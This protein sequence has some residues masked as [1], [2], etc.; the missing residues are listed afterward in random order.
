MTG[1]SII[2]MEDSAVKVLCRF[3][4]NVFVLLALTAAASAADLS[5]LKAQIER[6][7]P[8][9]RGE[10]GV[11]IK[12]LESG[13]EVLV[14]ADSR[15]PMASAFKLPILVELYYQKA[16]GKLSLE[17]HVDIEPAD[18]HIG[19]GAMIA[20]F[21]PPGVQINIRNLI[22]MMMR[23]SDNSAADILLKRVGPANVT[24]RMKA[25]GLDSIR[26]DRTTQEMIL[27]QSG[28][29]YS[30]YGALPVREVRKMLD[31]VDVPTAARANDQFNRTDKDVAKPGDMNA[32]LEKLYRGQIVDRSTSDEIIDILKECQTGPAR[33]PGLLPADT[34]IAHKTGTI[35]GSINDTGIVFLPYEAGHVAITVL[36][37]DARAATAERE[38]VIADITRYAYDY[39]IFNYGKNQ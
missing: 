4:V 12:H 6:T 13:S 7:I 10:V 38:R 24:S 17:D 22:N 16:A 9:A 27:D 36:M 20:L 14:N 18:L 37:K 11:A 33:I 34:V 35:G 23:I 28:L 25:L 2:E 15:Y 8:R 39:F 30:R 5:I 32:I 1:N 19:S 26:V 29:D 21:D 31:A 3:G